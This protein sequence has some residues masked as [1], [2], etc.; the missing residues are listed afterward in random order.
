MKLD[1]PTAVGVPL[2]VPFEPSCRPCGSDPADSDQVSEPPP[3]ALSVVEYGMPVVA[4]R[5]LEV[6]TASGATEPWIVLRHWFPDAYS[7]V[8]WIVEQLCASGLMLTPL[9][10]E[11]RGPNADTI[12]RY[13]RGLVRNVEQTGDKANFPAA[14]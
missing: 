5:R 4:I 1:V 11:V 2:I 13:Y 7:R 8:I 9:E 10:A 3:E 6:V 12:A 14:G